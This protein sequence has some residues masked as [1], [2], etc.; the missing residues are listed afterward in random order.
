M[1]D[2]T[3]CG[4]RSCKSKESCYRYMATPD[5]YQSWSTFGTIDCEKCTN[6]WPWDS[7]KGRYT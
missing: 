7:T 6:Y 4:N 3:M 1:A 5:K 2:I